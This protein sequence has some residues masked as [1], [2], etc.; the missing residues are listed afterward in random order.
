MS[1]G[2]GT[3]KKDISTLIQIERKMV[4]RLM[5]LTLFCPTHALIHS[6]IGYLLCKKHYAAPC[7][8]NGKI[9]SKQTSVSPVLRE[10]LVKWRDKY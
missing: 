2:A 10:I 6:A 5:I 9:T 1:H 7:G 4:I 3:I 8:Y